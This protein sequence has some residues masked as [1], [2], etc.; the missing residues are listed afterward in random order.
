MP[1]L[2]PTDFQQPTTDIL[3]ATPY[4]RETCTRCTVES[5]TE[6]YYNDR[7]QKVRLE[8]AAR[9]FRLNLPF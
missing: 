4:L 7:L 9:V 5:V 2:M 8:P 1:I 3:P 6:H